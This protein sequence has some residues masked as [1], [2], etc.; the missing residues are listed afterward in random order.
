MDVEKIAG[1]I[2]E[3]F[4]GSLSGGKAAGNP[5]SDPEKFPLLPL[6]EWV[7]LLVRPLSGTEMVFIDRHAGPD[8]IKALVNQPDFPFLYFTGTSLAARPVFVATGQPASVPHPVVEPAPGESV[9]ITAMP[10]DVAE[11]L[12]G[13]LS[14]AAPANAS[15]FRK[16][17]VLLQPERKE[18]FY[19][20]SYAVF[21]GLIGLSLPLGVQS[22]IGF[23]SSG[24]V[25][26]SA[27]ILVTFILVGILLSGIMTIF[28]LELVE[29][30]QQKLFARTAFSFAY[31]VP[32]IRLE[33]VLKHYPPELM[34]RFFDTLTL[35]KGVPV[36]LIDLS[37]AFL[38]VLFGVILL[39]FY[40][41][42]FILFGVFLSFL[43]YV[44][45]RYTGRKAVQTALEESDQK[46][47]VANWL[48]ELARSLSTFKL[49]GDSTL[50]LGKTDEYVGRYVNAREKH[51][52]V[53]KSQ[54]YSFVIFKTLITAILLVLGTVLIVD[55]QINLGQFVAAEIVI[56]L[57]INSIEKIIL[58]ID[59]VYDV[60]AGVEKITKVTG[61]PL[62]RSGIAAPDVRA[63]DGI[64]L[65]VKDLV[66]GYP[67]RSERSLNGL[68]FTIRSG[69][70]V[71]LTGTNGSGKST[72]IQL[73]LGLYEP[74]EGRIMYNG[75]SL[76]SLNKASLMNHIGNY[77]AMDTLFDG[78][79]HENIV[80]G[81]R[82]ISN[83]D[84]QWAIDIAGVRDFIESLPDGLDTR[85]I[86]GGFRL[87]ESIVHKLILARNIAEHPSLLIIDDFLLG[88]EVT[89]KRRILRFLLDKKNPWTVVLVSTDP[90]VLASVERVLWLEKGGLKAD[91]SYEEL[92]KKYGFDAREQD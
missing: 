2:Q 34:N 61:L 83:S 38:Q 23:I 46:Y 40:H 21:V 25:V 36:L 7:G 17:L 26:T 6:H 85:L 78:T 30:L 3:L 68:S 82:N 22:L 39:A 65:T 91:D 60:M 31:R 80:L 47:N 73:L 28:Q 90:L 29:R 35:Q 43:L 72:L 37:A 18:I 42:V 87:P 92:S 16:L 32:R 41:P 71:C 59:D 50:A 79:V 56:I 13:N 88:V 15:P 84:V 55:R 67:D 8:E 1:S 76:K 52:K 53:L 10:M 5:Q 4:K 14:D 12:I 75:I 74:H 24:Q 19:I 69:E 89:E 9:I 57:I 63:G 70:R 66:F 86:G 44:V 11:S 45:I 58:K 20:L 62:E 77:V 49:S 48:E 33:A 54:Y 27:V 51:F 81:R 64:S